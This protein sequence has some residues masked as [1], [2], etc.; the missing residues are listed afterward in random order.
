[1]F[2]TRLFKDII[3]ES[4][5]EV[6]ENTHLPDESSKARLLTRMFS[7][8]S[9]PPNLGQQEHVPL[10]HPELQD[11]RLLR[12]RAWKPQIFRLD[13]YLDKAQF[14]TASLPKRKLFWTWLCT[15]WR[16]IKPRQTLIRTANFPVWPSVDGSLLPLDGLCEPRSKHVSS[17]MGDAITR[18]S[19]ELLRSGLVSRTGKGR[20]T[21]RNMPSFQEFEG[22]LAAKISRFPRERR[23]TVNERREFH[24]LEKDLA[25]LASS[26][27][28]L[29]KYLGELDEDHYVA[30][31]KNGNLRVPGKLVRD[32]GGL[33]RLHLLD[34]H[35][36]DRPNSILDRIDGWNPR[37]APSTDQIVETFRVDGARFD[38]HVPRLQAYVRQS[39]RERK[40][41][42]IG[43]C[44]V[45]CIPVEGKL[46]SPNEIALRG[47]R[48]FWGHWEDTCACD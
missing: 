25:V 22:F 23:L 28:L 5:L 18:P 45:L 30:L 29:R 4:E 10:L 27:S 8:I 47:S 46:R 13:D 42:A 16:T 34:E 1:M 40:E 7:A 43:L 19:R 44:D 41:P 2:C 9:L 48:D 11:H 15:N 38:A 36:I 21:F 12:K 20:L 31:D 35:I 26:S 24:K 32:A 6:I 17:I 37:T 14:E 39:K 33:Q 3:W